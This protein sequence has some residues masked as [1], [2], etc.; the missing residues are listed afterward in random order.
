MIHS[1]MEMTLHSHRQKA[2]RRD[3][4]SEGLSLLT[5]FSLYSRRLRQFFEQGTILFWSYHI[6]VA[7]LAIGNLDDIVA[8]VQDV[9]LPRC[10]SFLVY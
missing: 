2:I 5:R 9:Q 3:I 6:D 8:G 10:G 7:H 4:R 1:R